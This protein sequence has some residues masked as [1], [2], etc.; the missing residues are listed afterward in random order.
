MKLGFNSPRRRPYRYVRLIVNVAGYYLYRSIPKPE[1]PSYTSR[2]VTVI[3]P[4]IESD[5]EALRGPI[6]SILACRPHELILV[7]TY[8]KYHDLLDFALSLK[9]PCVKVYDTKFANKR[10]QLREAIPRVTS[11]ITVLVDDDVTWPS[12]I[13]P[14]V[15]APF[16]RPQIGSVSVCQRVKRVRDGSLMGRCFNWL[17][18]CYIQRRNF[19][20]AASHFFDGGTSCMSGRTNA[21]RTDILVNPLFLEGFCNERWGKY[22]LNADDDNFVT[23]WLVNHDWKTWIQYEPECEIETTL[24]N[25]WAFVRQCLRW[26]RSTWRSNYTTLFIEKKVYS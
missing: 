13:L 22:H 9:D 12:T 20:I 1:S 21:V 23:R 11:R 16:E 4:T 15:L 5:V 19:E 26:A 17:G 7:T 3:I 2:D 6:T 14:W 18:A 25:D 10:I 8:A 24:E